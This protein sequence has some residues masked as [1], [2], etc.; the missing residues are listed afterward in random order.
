M[1]FAK[2]LVKC[3]FG[4]LIAMTQHERFTDK[5]DQKPWGG[6]HIWYLIFWVI[7]DP[8]LPYLWLHENIHGKFVSLTWFVLLCSLCDTQYCTVTNMT[9]L[10]TEKIRV[11]QKN[12]NRNNL[13]FSRS[14]L[15][16]FKPVCLHTRQWVILKAKI[17]N[18]HISLLIFFGKWILK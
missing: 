17:I 11:F 1:D 18:Q 13:Q 8:C 3:H 2:T 14:I 10:A 12:Q 16:L 7:V 9:A 5:N 15:C 4:H 6:I